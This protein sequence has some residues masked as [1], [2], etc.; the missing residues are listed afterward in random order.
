MEKDNI[1]IKRQIL[2]FNKLYNKKLK[3]KKSF[4]IWKLILLL[5]V[6]ICFAI[7]VFISIFLLNIYMSLPDIRDIEKLTIAQSTIIYDKNGNELYKIHGDENRQYISLDQISPYMIQA[8]ISA[9]D[10]DFYRHS[11][12]D[13]SAMARAVIAKIRN[14]QSKLQGGSTITQQLIKNLLL[15]SE[16]TIDR[17]LRELMLAYQLENTYTKDKIIE[18]YLNQVP[19]GSNAYGIEMAARTFFGKNASELDLLESAILAGLPRGPSFYSPY[20]HRDRLVGYCKT[21]EYEDEMTIDTLDITIV[22]TGRVW[23]AVSVDGDNPALQTGKILNPSEKLE[24]RAQEKIDISFGN[25]NYNILYNGQKLDKT[26]NRR[27]TINFSD[28][29]SLNNTSTETVVKEYKCESMDDEN[30]VIGRKDY[31][32]N[33]MYEDGYIT[34]EELHDAWERGNTIKFNEY[35]ANIKYPHFVM[36]V[37]EYLENKYGKEIV[38]KGGLRVYTTIDPDLQDIAQKLIKDQAISNTTRHN[39]SNASLL[40]VDPKT[41]HIIAMVGSRDYFDDKIDGKVNITTSFRQ[42]GSAFKPFV[43][44]NLFS[45]GNYGAGTVLWDLRTSFNGAFPNNAD[46]TFRGPM[47]VKEALAQSRNIPAIKAFLLAGGE[48]NMLDFVEKIGMGYLKTRNMTYGWPLAIGTGEVRMMD[49][50]RGFSV[51]ARE[52]RDVEITPILKIIDSNNIVLEEFDP[53]KRYDQIMERGVANVINY[54]LSDANARP[55]GTWR[56]TLTIPGYNVASKTGTSNK[57]ISA[58]LIL[59]SDGWTFSYTP[60]LVVGVWAGNND[61]S[62]LNRGAYGLSIIAPAL[63]QFLIEALPKFDKDEFNLDNTELVSINRFNGFKVSQSTPAGVVI[64]ERFPIGRSPTESDNSAKYIDV[65][66]RNNLLVNEY[67]PPDVIIEA[68]VLNLNSMM[69]NNQAWESPVQAYIKSGALNEYFTSEEGSLLLSSVPK[70][71][72]PLCKFVSEEDRPTINITSPLH[73]SEIVPPTMFVSA[74]VSSSVNISRVEYYF[75]DELKHTSVFSPYSANINIGEGYK[76]DSIHKLKA[77]VYD[78]NY[79]SA[80]HTIEVKIADEDINPPYVEILEPDNNSTFI[81]GNIVNI[82]VNA[83]DLESGIKEVTLYVN[84]RAVETRRNSPFSF[85]LNSGNYEA[86][87]LNIRVKALDNY[88]NETTKNLNIILVSD[89]NVIEEEIEEEEIEEEDIVDYDEEILDEE[90]EIE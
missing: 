58:N 25:L 31:I 37:K 79:Y 9:E 53:N 45:N 4:V 55:A 81:I 64:S 42:P 1:F 3:Q 56:N 30:Y 33:R 16:V 61:G 6:L 52:G 50:V 43:Y 90:E 28:I 73:M 60:N 84:N 66:K 44:G 70:E 20:N 88:D 63:K 14:P 87:N 89:Q 76:K 35:R 82:N 85:R 10:K 34:Q 62:P 75:N 69:P 19:F 7:S 2:Y 29:E 12:F 65:D 71:E 18:L 24:I 57:R 78:E 49:M 13:L 68:F 83:Y 41:G 40:A 77:V 39:A 26:K 59:P 46:G 38:E 23:V 36:H 67:C 5:F 80:T 8:T 11:G 21:V 47:T 15:T 27:M 51:F 22:A 32:L 74:D 48:E 72:S 86:G 17:K 54:I